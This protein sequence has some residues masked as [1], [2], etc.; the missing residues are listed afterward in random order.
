MHIH[1]FVCAFAVADIVLSYTLLCVQVHA[2]Q[3][4]LCLHF[5]S[6]SNGLAIAFLWS[7]CRVLLIAHVCIPVRTNAHSISADIV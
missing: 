5:V 4:C 7:W 1:P 3:T 6:F 2:T